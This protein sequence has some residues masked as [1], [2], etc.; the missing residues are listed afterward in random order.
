ME[1]ALTRSLVLCVGSVLKAQEISNEVWESGLVRKAFSML[2][3]LSQQDSGSVRRALQDELRDI[4]ESH[5]LHGFAVTSH[6][7]L[8]QLEALCRSFDGDDAQDLLNYL[9]VFSHL[10]NYLHSDSIPT[11]FS[12]LLQVRFPLIAYFLVPP[13]L[14]S[15]PRLGPPPPLRRASLQRSLR[16][17]RSALLAVLAAA[18]PA[19][20]RHGLQQRHSGVRP[21]DVSLRSLLPQAAQRGAAARRDS[22]RGGLFRLGGLGGAQGDLAVSHRFLRLSEDRS[23]EDRRRMASRSDRA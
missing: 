6:Y 13:A 20:P 14:R 15:A 12:T 7:L 10:V 9:L 17:G 1:P 22:R 18:E 11:L 16:C 5:F 8:R 3:S 2:L 21:R 23:A 4:L 19:D